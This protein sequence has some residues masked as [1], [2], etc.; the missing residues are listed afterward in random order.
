MK[1]RNTKVD[2]LK[3]WS[4]EQFKQVNKTLVTYFRGKSFEQCTGYNSMFKAYEYQFV[5]FHGLK[6][7]Q[8][9]LGLVFTSTSSY[10][11]YFTTRQVYID[12]DRLY[13]FHSFALSLDGYVYAVLMDENENELCLRISK[14]SLI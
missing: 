13:Y 7:V 12:A 4:D 10:A 3:E 6:S 14:T 11:A 2:F 5:S 1:T 9:V 8:D